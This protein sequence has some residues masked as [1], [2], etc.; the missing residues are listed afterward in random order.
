MNTDAPNLRPDSFMLSGR[1]YGTLFGLTGVGNA[2]II[3]MESILD[4]FTYCSYTTN[5]K[6]AFHRKEVSYEKQIRR[7]A[8]RAWH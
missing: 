3:F 8:K 6:Q 2:N 4:I 1:F 7:V 5:V